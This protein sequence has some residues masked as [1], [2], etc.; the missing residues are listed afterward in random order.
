MKESKKIYV[1]YTYMDYEQN[2]EV[3]TKRELAE[4]YYINKIQKLFE[5][6]GVKNKKEF[7]EDFYDESNGDKREMYD[8]ILCYNADNFELDFTT[9]QIDRTGRKGEE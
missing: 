9:Q 6:Y 2:I 7:M 3:F 5:Y 8:Q 4:E 1:I